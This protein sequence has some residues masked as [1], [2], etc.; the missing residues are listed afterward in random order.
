MNSESSKQ[1]RW[2][3]YDGPHINPM[4]NGIVCM[5]SADERLIAVIT[6]DEAMVHPATWPD[7]AN[8]I[9]AAP[10][11]AEYIA[12]RAAEGDQEA[13]RILGGINGTA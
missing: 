7:V 8:L 4:F 11:M 12:K 1:M 13:V 6:E 3:V 2:K 10:T 9:A 5:I